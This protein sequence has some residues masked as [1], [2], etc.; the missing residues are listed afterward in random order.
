[1]VWRRTSPPW[2]W[3]DWEDHRAYRRLCATHWRRGTLRRPPR[4]LWRAGAREGQA[5]PCPG[6]GPTTS[7]LTWSIPEDG[8]RRLRANWRAPSAASDAVGLDQRRRTSECSS[9]AMGA[10]SARA[11]STAR[12]GYLPSKRVL[13]AR[14]LNSSNESNQVAE[15]ASAR[16]CSDAV[17]G[18]TD[19]LAGASA[20]SMLRLTTEVAA[21][22]GLS[23][24]SVCMTCWPA[25]CSSPRQVRPDVAAL[26][27][28][29]ATS[30]RAPDRCRGRCFSRCRTLLC[31]RCGPSRASER[32]TSTLWRSRRSARR[33]K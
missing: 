1:M 24:A 2:P 27:S 23:P 12:S 8:A 9:P 22:C 32:G 29:P 18:S 10:T 14:L 3:I 15:A 21:P 30:R 28:S 26:E 13:D 5:P 25:T 7:T 33:R 6:G 17:R 4:W 19:H 31:S 11:R 16:H 20:S